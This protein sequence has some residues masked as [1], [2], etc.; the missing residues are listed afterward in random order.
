MC[1][2]EGPGAYVA[3][4]K[5]NDLIYYKD[6]NNRTTFTPDMVTTSSVTSNSTH[7]V[8]L[9][10]NS[11]VDDSANYTCISLVHEV[12]I[13]ELLP[14]DFDERSKASVLVSFI[15]KLLELYTVQVTIYVLR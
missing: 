9:I 5:F 10:T 15:G 4:H 1:S 13:N 3:W 6:I 2:W 7:S 11:T 8:L 14:A 12:A